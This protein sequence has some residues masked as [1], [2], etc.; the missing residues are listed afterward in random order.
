VLNNSFW[1]SDALSNDKV[2][3]LIGKKRKIRVKDRSESAVVIKSTRS[4]EEWPG[5]VEY[6][7]RYEVESEDDDGLIAVIQ[8]LSFRSDESGCIDYIQV[9]KHS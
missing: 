1:F 6:K 5:I 2:C 9:N 8:N 7:C 3:S 4:F